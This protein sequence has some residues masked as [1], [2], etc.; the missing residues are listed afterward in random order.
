MI[1]A[2]KMHD[3]FIRRK[4]PEPLVKRMKNPNTRQTK[5]MKEGIADEP[6]AALKY[7]EVTGM[8]CNI[9]PCGI[10]ISVTCPWLAAS[11]DRKVYCP[12][13]LHLD[14]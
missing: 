5:A 2:S 14:F 7:S 12:E 6:R 4:D 1:T 13:Y 10:V 11:P 9:L 3:I 8:K